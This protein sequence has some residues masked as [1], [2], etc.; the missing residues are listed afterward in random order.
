MKEYV[1][2][3]SATPTRSGKAAMNEA[4]S[5]TKASND[6]LLRAEEERLRLGTVRCGPEQVQGGVPWTRLA[7]VGKGAAPWKSSTSRTAE[8]SVV[9]RRA[10]EPETLHRTAD[11]QRW[12]PLGH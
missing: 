3:F 10:A 1:A 6:M 4:R 11:H 9:S 7:V 8:H 12:R 2:H 5:S